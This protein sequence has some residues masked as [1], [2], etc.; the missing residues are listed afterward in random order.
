MIRQKKCSPKKAEKY[1]NKK[2]NEIGIN[3]KG[4]I[5]MHRYIDEEQLLLLWIRE[6]DYT[7]SKGRLSY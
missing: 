1:L 3:K 7:P 6:K 5:M 2:K 4:A